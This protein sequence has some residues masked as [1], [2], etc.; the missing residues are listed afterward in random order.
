[1]RTCFVAL[2]AMP[3]QSAFRAARCDGRNGTPNAPHHIYFYPAP[4][5]QGDKPKDQ[6]KARNEFEDF[7][8]V[9]RFAFEKDP[10]ELDGRFDIVL[11]LAQGTFSP[12]SFNPEGLDDLENMR[13]AIVRKAG[14]RLRNAYLGNYLL[15]TAI[16]IVLILLVAFFAMRREDDPEV[17]VSIYALRMLLCGGMIGLLFSTLSRN[18]TPTYE[19]LITPKADLGP[20]WAKLVFY[21]ISILFFGIVFDQGWIKVSVGD[22]D[23]STKAIH[24]NVLAALVFGILLGAAERLLPPKLFK[25]SEKLVKGSDGK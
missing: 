1:M 7:T 12:Q 4:E 3:A 10:T 20:A 13:E 19:N 17:R 24:T 6:L 22:S 21:G 11:L 8:G 15:A 9:L 5:W 14:N 16:A 18:V 2:I 23:F 25:L